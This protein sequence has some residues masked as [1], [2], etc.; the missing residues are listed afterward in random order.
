VKRS[1]LSLRSE[2]PVEAP[3]D[4]KRRYRRSLL[5][6]HLLLSRKAQPRSRRKL[7]RKKK[8]RR[9]NTRNIRNMAAQNTNTSV[10]NTKSTKKKT[11]H[12]RTQKV[13]TKTIRKHWKG[14]SE[15]KLCSLCKDTTNPLR[16][17]RNLK[18]INVI[19]LLRT[20]ASN[21][22]LFGKKER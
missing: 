3:L 10:Q 11:S 1:L 6:N 12:Q 2:R 9:R 8:K 16:H 13:W 15:R 7:K 4:K 20:P 14:N 5:V 22:A 18:T 19:V 17:R 21:T